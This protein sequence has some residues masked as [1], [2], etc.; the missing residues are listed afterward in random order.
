MLA[1]WRWGP[2]VWVAVR[3]QYWQ[4]KCLAY[5]A[6]PGEVVVDFDPVAIGPTKS[7]ASTAPS[8]AAPPRCWTELNRLAG[9]AVGGGTVLFLHERV[10]RTGVRRLVAIQ[11]GG[12]PGPFVVVQLIIPASGLNPLKPDIPHIILQKDVV[13]F[14]DGDLVMRFGPGQF[15][16]ADSSHLTIPFRM[17]QGPTAVAGT[18][19]AWLSDNGNSMRLIMNT[20]EQ[21]DASSLAG[22]LQTRLRKGQLLWYRTPA[23]L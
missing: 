3:V 4:R 13:L 9:N 6:P 10:S 15:D 5:D 17:G 22:N 1:G 12:K 2:R 21:P 20:P 16:P 23:Q 18:L 7:L 8:A 11:A 19:E 14:L